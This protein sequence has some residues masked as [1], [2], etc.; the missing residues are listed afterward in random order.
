ML[1]D[2]TFLNIDVVGLSVVRIGHH[3]VANPRGKIDNSRCF[4]AVFV[5]NTSDIVDIYSFI[6][7]L[8]DPLSGITDFE[9]LSLLLLSQFNQVSLFT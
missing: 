9:P 7:C 5:S 8:V 4:E 2:L 1:D 3:L 6:S